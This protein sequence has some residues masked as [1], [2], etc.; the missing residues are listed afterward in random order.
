MS[1]RPVAPGGAPAPSGTRL[2]LLGRFA[3][4]RES[5]SILVPVGVQ[6]LLAFL[7]LRGPSD[8]HTVAGTLWPEVGEAQALASL[9][10]CVW[11]LNKALPD[12]LH[13]FG[14]ALAIRGFI[15]L[16]SRDQE[17]FAASLL[18]HERDDQDWLKD[19][20]HLLWEGELLPGWYDD[21]VIFE[22][23]RL[24]QL[25]L[26]ALELAA[27]LLTQRGQLDVAVQLA[28]EAVRTEPL[29]ETANA[30]LM[31]VYLAEGNV[32]DAV[33]Q[34]VLFRDLL[35]RELAL[36]PSP[37]LARLLPATKTF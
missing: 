32:S 6:R 35:Q 12:V 22:R 11:R 28:L 27:S 26:H 5:A 4:Q 33:H 2:C 37:Q 3:L 23:E 36:E 9:R 30:V 17:S 18:S 20:L 25:R 24:N 7:A 14:P 19:K 34:Y 13:Q 8:R 29:R 21:W 31:S 10:T 1:S 15:A 16:D